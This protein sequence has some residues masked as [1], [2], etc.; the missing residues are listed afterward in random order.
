MRILFSMLGIVATL[1]VGSSATAQAEGS[2][3]VPDSTVLAVVT[4]FYAS[5]QGGDAAAVQHLVHPNAQLF[6]SLEAGESRVNTFESVAA[7]VRAALKPP[8]GW[9][10]VQ[11]IEPT[12]QVSESVAVVWAGFIYQAPGQL[13]CGTETYQLVRT[14]DQWQIVAIANDSN[15]SACELPVFAGKL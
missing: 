13:R 5:L 12:T 2:S 15:Q 8:A 4:D 11:L 1:G 10:S 7:F 3:T 6:V 14:A 9:W